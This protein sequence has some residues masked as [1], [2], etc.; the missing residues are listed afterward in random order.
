MRSTDSKWQ[1]HKACALGLGLRPLLWPHNNH[2][3]RLGGQACPP[4]TAHHKTLQGLG[5]WCLLGL[6]KTEDYALEWICAWTKLAHGEVGA[7]SQSEAMWTAG[8]DPRKKRGWA[9]Q[10]QS[11]VSFA[12]IKVMFV[13]GHRLSSFLFRKSQLLASS[14]LSLSLLTAVGISSGRWVL[15]SFHLC[16]FSLS[17][18]ADGGECLFG[19]LIRFC[20]QGL[21]RRGKDL[22]CLFFLN[23]GHSLFSHG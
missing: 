14:F 21:S 10:K 12:S 17:A 16:A 4:P 6:S 9:A 20:P 22:E 5:S 18:H 19:Y 8:W 13:R 3:A 2:R 11:A 15:S 7:E 23:E 1:G